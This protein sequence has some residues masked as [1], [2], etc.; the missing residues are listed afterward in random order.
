MVAGPMVDAL[1]DGAVGQHGGLLLAGGHGR[2]GR[3]QA[4]HHGQSATGGGFRDQCP[5]HRL[6]QAARQGQA[7]TDPGAVRRVAEPLE[8]LKHLVTLAVRDARP[9]V[10][11]AQLDPFALLAGGDQRRPVRRTIVQRVADQVDQDP[12]E[13]AG[14]GRGR[15]QV[16]GDAHDDRAA[17]LTDFVQ[18]GRDRVLQPHPRCCH[19]ERTGLQPAHVEQVLDQPSQPLE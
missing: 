2:L 18:R 10:D 8:R 6:G 9:V 1:D 16:I 19:A 14:V 7:E 15:G 4:Q 11:D 3:R 5:A 13:Q 17:R 12:L